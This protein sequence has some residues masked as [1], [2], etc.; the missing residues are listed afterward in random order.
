MDNGSQLSGSASWASCLTTWYPTLGWNQFQSA[1][2][3]AAAALAQAMKPDY[4]VLA[5]E[6]DTESATTGYTE[7]DTPA[8]AVSML[9]EI[10]ASVVPLKPQI[11]NMLVGAG[12]GNWQAIYYTD[13]QSFANA[14]TSQACS[15]SQP[16]VQPKLDFFDMHLFLI[17]ESAPAV[18]P[19][20]PYATNFQKN[21]LAMISAAKAAGMPMTIS[22]AWLRKVRDS[23]WRNESSPAG[24]STVQEARETYSFWAPLDSQWLTTLERLASQAQMAFV[25][26][27]DTDEMSAYQTWSTS[28]SIE[29]DGGSLPAT[30]VFGNE[31]PVASSAALNCVYSTTGLSLYRSIA[32]PDTVPPSSPAQLAFSLTSKSGVRLTWTSSSDN[33][34]VAG[35]H[36]WRDAIRLPDTFSTTATDSGILQN[37]SYLY[38]VE[39]FD[40]AGNVSQ[41]ATVIV[42]LK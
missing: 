37:V 15:S 27:F 21:A 20:P 25:V 12:F 30:Q 11:P 29:E 24:N 39:A 35:Y 33:V 28:T 42:F 23:E 19:N 5:Q 16:C 7:I 40:L 9:N 6:P 36:V 34:G 8:G 18:G 4:F 13:Y 32:P 2:A 1:R 38:Q 22:Q 10:M 17:N 14:Y 3:Q 31:G 26:P 41:P